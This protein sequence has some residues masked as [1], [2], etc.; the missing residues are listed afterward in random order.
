MEQVSEIEHRLAEHSAVQ[1]AHVEV[2]NDAT[3][4]SRRLVAKVMLKSAYNS[5]LP[6]GSALETNILD[7]NRFPGLEYYTLPNGMVVAHQS[8]I[9][10]QI[11][12]PEIFEDEEYLRHGITL[13]EGDCVFDVGANI[14]M[15]TLFAHQKCK[16]M[17]VYAFEPGPSIFSVLRA[18]TQRPGMENIKI[19]EYGLSNEAKM[20]PL[21]FFPYMSGM[22]GIFSDSEK[23]KNI[24]KRGIRNWLQP[25][26]RDEDIH[27]LAQELDSKLGD[28]FA[29]SQKQLCQFRTL[30][31]VIDEHTIDAIDLLKIDAEKSE[32]DVLMGIRE[33]DWGKIKQVVAEVHSEHLLRQVLAL[34]ERQGY[35]VVVEFEEGTVLEEDFE[36]YDA[37]RLYMV[38]A[39]RHS[40]AGWATRKSQKIEYVKVPRPMLSIDELRLFLNAELPNYHLFS[41]LRHHL[42]W[43]Y[44][45]SIFPID[46]ELTAA[47]PLHYDAEL[48]AL[49]VLHESLLEAH[50]AREEV[51][52][53]EEISASLASSSN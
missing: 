6:G 2:R 11:L 21:V 1:C 46:F 13:A 25:G 18:N 33:E 40:H 3:G 42:Q 30:S 50:L 28:W 4:S 49:P 44:S 32:L 7:V 5:L 38:Y 16:N 36:K 53:L 31:T 51:M 29:H 17:R 47:F 15:F 9:Q 35:D 19:F 41:D 43:K 48:P 45:D 12:Y 26:E 52:Q 14:G 27:T 34:L 22:S 24:F 23:E 39:V 37:Y 8:A 10:T 20:A